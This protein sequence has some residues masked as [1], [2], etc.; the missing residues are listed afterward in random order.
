MKAEGV[1]DPHAATRAGLGL[2]LH[3]FM[4]KKTTYVS[5]KCCKIQMKIPFQ[6]YLFKPLV[7]NV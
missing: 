7:H 1:E 3:L 2:I 4:K 5:E 6:E